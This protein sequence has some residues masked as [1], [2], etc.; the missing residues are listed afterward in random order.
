MIKS[1]PQSAGARRGPHPRKP[2]A[3]DSEWHRSGGRHVRGE[4][5]DLSPESRRLFPP[6]KFQ[7]HDLKNVT[8]A[9]AALIPKCPSVG[10]K[11]AKTPSRLGRELASPWVAC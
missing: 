4:P 3:R 8:S 11:T 5:F 2:G 10:R 6:P 1:A 7:Q 9:E